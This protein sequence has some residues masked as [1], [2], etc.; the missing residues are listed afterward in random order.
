[1]YP[2]LSGEVAVLLAASAASQRDAIAVLPTPGLAARTRSLLGAFT[3]PDPPEPSAAPRGA[4][5]RPTVVIDRHDPPVTGSVE[6]MVVLAG[7]VRP[8]ATP[9][10]SAPG[11]AQALRR[12]L[13][14]LAP[15]ATVVLLCP[16]QSRREPDNPGG[17]LSALMGIATRAGLSY[18]QHVVL[19]HAPLADNALTPTSFEADLPGVFHPVHTDAFVYTSPAPGQGDAGE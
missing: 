3:E 4:G 8:G 9:P 2:G 13:G 10:A 12:W 6:L 5:R 16:P 7:P 1:V 17:G 18:V 15:G 14:G 19:V 11:A